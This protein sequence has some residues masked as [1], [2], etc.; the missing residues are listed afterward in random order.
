MQTFNTGDAAVQVVSPRE[1]TYD[2][3]YLHFLIMG[4][5]IILALTA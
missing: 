5:C 2:P 3:I 4:A 1:G